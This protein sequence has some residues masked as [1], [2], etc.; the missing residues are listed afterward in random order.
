MSEVR[1]IFQFYK[2]RILN[3][4]LGRIYNYRFLSSLIPLIKYIFL[5]LD[6]NICVLLFLSLE[7]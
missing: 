2:Y 6:Y 3:T 1:R 7:Y 4:L 5:Y